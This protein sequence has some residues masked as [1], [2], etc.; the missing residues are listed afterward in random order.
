M[1]KT[2]VLGKEVLFDENGIFYTKDSKVYKKI[3][4][5]FFK[6]V[7]TPEGVYTYLNSSSK[8]HIVQ[9]CFHV[10]KDFKVYTTDEELLKYRRSLI[11]K[12]KECD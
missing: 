2:L 10:D 7:K 11:K 8:E 1:L 5:K 4:E 9:L 12:H 6:K 3:I